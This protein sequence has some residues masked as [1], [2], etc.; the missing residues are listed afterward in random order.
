MGW[1]PTKKERRH[2]DTIYLYT[3]P[4]SI[5]RS[6]AEKTA[7]KDEKLELLRRRIEKIYAI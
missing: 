1:R 6:E 7:E 5:A 4:E 3:V 2:G